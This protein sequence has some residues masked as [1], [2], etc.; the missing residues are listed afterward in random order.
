MSPS[1]LN[2]RRRC[3]GAT[4]AVVGILVFLFRFNALG[5]SMFGFDD[6]HFLSLA[7]ASQLLAGEWPLRDYPDASLQGAWPPLAYLTSAGAQLLVGRNLLA[8]ALL[9]AGAVA[10]AAVITMLVGIRLRLPLVLA[11]AAA[12]ISVLPS[13]RLYG[14]ARPLLFAACAL[15]LHW[16]ASRPSV[17]RAGG[18]AALLAIAFVVRHDYAIYL[19]PGVLIALLARHFREPYVGLRHMLAVGL[20]TGLLLTPSLVS[21]QVLSGIGAYLTE[22]S[23]LVEDERQRTDEGGP[24]ALDWSEV[25]AEENPVAWLYY[26]YFAVPVLAA[27]VALARARR[28][29]DPAELPTVLGTSVV[30]WLASDYLLR[31][32]LEARIADPAVMPA[33]LG[34]WLVSVA[35]A[36][37]WGTWPVARAACA[38]GATTL[39]VVTTVAAARVGSFVSELRSA[40]LI[41]GPLDTIQHTVRVGRELAGAPESLW[42]EP[43]PANGPLLAAAYLHTCTRESDRILNVRYS[44]EAVVLSGRRFAAGRMNFLPG[45]YET[46][47]E[48]RRVVAAASQQV[49]PIVLMEEGE[50]A[51]ELPEEFPILAAYLAERYQDVGAI[52]Y[53]DREYARVLA[54]RGLQPVR[55]FGATGLPC[56]R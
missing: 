10:A 26:V 4:A 1:A 27:V 56:F 33:I 3:I 37:P 18:L 30:C 20:F 40:R 22:I 2:R 31:N 8:E 32:N 42:R 36:R 51:S 54:W 46:E 48:E 35:W 5:G 19:G 14:W 12:I 7:R 55:M 21:V 6:D 11:V 16:Y 41:D 43:Y 25:N 28:S 53:S 45:H 39:L 38:V 15:L 47:Q 29:G 52:N 17:R 44:T 9:T 34:L 50:L 49:I 13:L 23:A 24:P